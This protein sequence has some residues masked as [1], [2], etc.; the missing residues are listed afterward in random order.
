MTKRW[1]ASISYRSAEQATIRDDRE[2]EELAELQQL[3]EAGPDWNCVEQ[4]EIA[5]QRRLK[6]QLTLEESAHAGDAR[7]QKLLRATLASPSSA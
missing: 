3:V 2:M 6:P 5:L 4:I 7:A 1:V